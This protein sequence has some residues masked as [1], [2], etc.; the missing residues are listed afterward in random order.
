MKHQI[1]CLNLKLEMGEMIW[2]IENG[3]SFGQETKRKQNFNEISDK[4]RH[5]I[6]HAYAN[7]HKFVVSKA[8]YTQTTH[9]V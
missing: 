5:I 2:K 8:W 6:R 7:A 4:M 3:Q 1:Y 9:N